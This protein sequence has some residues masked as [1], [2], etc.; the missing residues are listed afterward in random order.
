MPG[1]PF[2]PA[3]CRWGTGQRL[4]DA[5]GAGIS[6]RFRNERIRSRGSKDSLLPTLESLIDHLAITLRQR[7]WQ[8]VPMKR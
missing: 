1:Y 8:P 3:G 7:P 4:A 6:R 2:A 5:A